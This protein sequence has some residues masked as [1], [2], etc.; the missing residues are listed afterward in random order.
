VTLGV[1]MERGELEALVRDA[2]GRDV[3]GT[4]DDLLLG[5][6]VRLCARRCTF[7]ER[8]EGLLDGRTRDARQHADGC[9]LAELAATWLNVREPVDGP[10]LAALLWSLARDGRWLLDPLRERVQAD[11]WVRALRLLARTA[12]PPSPACGRP[13]RPTAPRPHALGASAQGVTSPPSAEDQR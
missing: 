7:A 12:A 3:G 4:R 10:R 1:L 6:A 11:I 13:S 5:D 2:T 8:I 9:P